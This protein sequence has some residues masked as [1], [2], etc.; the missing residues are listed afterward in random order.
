MS[1]RGLTK[2]C[3]RHDI[4]VPPRGYWAKKQAGHDVD[5]IPLPKIDNPICEQVHLPKPTQHPPEVEALRARQLA[6][7]ETPDEELVIPVPSPHKLLQPVIQKV[8]KQKAAFILN[9]ARFA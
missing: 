6:E 2:I 8:R 3:I 1:D 4:P 9:R 7:R 5:E